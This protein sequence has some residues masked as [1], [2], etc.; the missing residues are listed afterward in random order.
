MFLIHSYPWAV[1]GC[2][3]TMF[4]WGSF[5]NTHKLSPKTWRYELYYWDY[6]AGIAVFVLAAGL[7]LGSLG[8][9]GRPLVAD[10]AQGSGWA[11]A[12]ALLSG[13]IFNAGNILLMAAID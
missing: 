12:M 1:A 7:S 10:M 4:C 6:V 2:V 13:T 3:A 8:P 11:W 5:A 9:E